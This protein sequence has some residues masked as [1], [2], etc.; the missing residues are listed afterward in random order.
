MSS[1][2]LVQSLHVQDNLAWAW[3]G[4][5]GLEQSNSTELLFSGRGL[6]RVT[7]ES[8]ARDQDHTRPKVY[9]RGNDLVKIKQN[10]ATLFSINTFP[11]HNFVSD[12]RVI[13]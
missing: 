10:H 13:L 6:V 9:W 8:A 7:Q 12:G 2:I 5:G 11:I 4:T 1:F 3:P